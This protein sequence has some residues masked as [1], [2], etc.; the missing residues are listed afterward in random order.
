MRMVIRKNITPVAT[1]FCIFESESGLYQ[2]YF[3][4][5]YN[6]NDILKGL[7]C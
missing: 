3:S 4:Q 2:V 7:T 6:K 5:V 1:I